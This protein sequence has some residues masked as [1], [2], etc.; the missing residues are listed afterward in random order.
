MRMLAWR[1]AA[2]P[3]DDDVVSRHLLNADTDA[4]AEAEAE[5]DVGV[6]ERG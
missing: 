4:D 6:G 5:A 1:K 3:W 2:F